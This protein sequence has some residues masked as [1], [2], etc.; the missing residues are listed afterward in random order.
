MNVLTKQ[1]RI[2]ELMKRKPDI[3]ITSVNHY[4]DKELMAEALSLLKKDAAPGVDGV[5]VTE[6]KGMFEERVD[7]LIGPIKTG[8][9]KAPHVRRTYIPK[10]KAEMRPLGIPTVEDKL[11]Q[12]AVQLLFEPI[13]ENVFLDCSYAF[14]PERSV[15]QALD[16]IW[17]NAMDMNGCWVLDIDVSKYFDCVDHKYLREFLQLRVNDGVINRLIGKWLKAGI[18][19]KGQVAF[20]DEGTPQGGVISPLLANVYLHYVLDEWFYNE[21]KPRLKCEAELVRYADDFVILIKDE[22]EAKRMWEVLPKRLE[23]YGLK[24][25]DKKSKLVNFTIPKWYRKEKGEAFDFLG[26]THYWKR[27]NGKSPII[28]QKTS[29]KSFSKSMKKFHDWLK[30]NRHKDIAWQHKKL[31]QKLKGYYAHYKIIGNSRS[32]EV[33]KHKVQK[34]WRYW[35]NRRHRNNAMNWKKFEKLLERYPLPKVSET[36]IVGKTVT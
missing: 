24:M 21:V 26:F 7:E 14:R 31:C 36:R 25:N 15:H 17:K 3:Q 19:D 8:R 30:R 18:W 32:V 16:R 20:P 10:S 9:Y 4:I 23:K 29:S 2:A 28:H 35:L 12:K 11:A 33:F 13:Y 27:R 5:T 1:L 34:Y 22:Q 6:Y